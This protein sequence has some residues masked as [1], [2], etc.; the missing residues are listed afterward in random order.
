MIYAIY[1]NRR[2]CDPT[3]HFVETD[4]EEEFLQIL[5]KLTCPQPQYS[6]EIVAICSKAKYIISLEEFVERYSWDICNNNNDKFSE[7]FVE[8]RMRLLDANVPFSVISQM[9]KR[10]KE[11]LN[12]YE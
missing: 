11:T 2:Y 4:L 12:I 10:I 6:P 1:D 9:T 3:T 5:I 7:L 8:N